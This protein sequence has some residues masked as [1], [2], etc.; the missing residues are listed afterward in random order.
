MKPMSTK[1]GRHLLVAAIVAVGAQATIIAPSASADSPENALA[2]TVTSGVFSD[3]LRKFAK[4]RG[5]QFITI[6]GGAA[7]GYEC[8]KVLDGLDRGQSG[9]FDLRMPNGTV[10]SQRLAPRDFPT[11]TPTY[12][13]WS[14]RSVQCSGW[15]IPRFYTECM[16]YQLDPL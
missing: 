1:R 5:G 8:N 16:Q 14:P 15:T 11:W 12:D 6:L 7:A 2:C 4:F 9:R 13:Q 3:W 10:L